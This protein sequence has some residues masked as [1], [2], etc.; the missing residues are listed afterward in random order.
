MIECVCVL[1]RGHRMACERLE[2]RIGMIVY[3]WMI[4]IVSYRRD[5]K[6]V[7]RVWSFAVVLRGTLYIISCGTFNWIGLIW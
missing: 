2:Y 3:G 4:E 1:I 6:I 5:C 7:I